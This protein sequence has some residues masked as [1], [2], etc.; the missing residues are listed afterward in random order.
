[1]LRYYGWVLTHMPT[2]STQ[3]EDTCGQFHGISGSFHF[4]RAAQVRSRMGCRQ[5]LRSKV[6]VGHIVVRVRVGMEAG[7]KSSQGCPQL[8]VCVCLCASGWAVTYWLI[9]EQ[10][11]ARIS[12]SC[13]HFSMW[14]P[15]NNFIC[16]VWNYILSG[17]TIKANWV[18]F[19]RQWRLTVIH[20]AL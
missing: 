20:I 6:R 12:E 1:M 2:T 19:I 17:G 18:T 4:V 10:W 15:E 13:L 7:P 9:F 5:R 11:Y 8:H 14:F 3:S 16:G